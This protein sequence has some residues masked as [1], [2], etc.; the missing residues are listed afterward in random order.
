MDQNVKK[1]IPR[2]SSRYKKID[3]NSPSIMQS[4][5]SMSVLEQSRQIEDKSLDFGGPNSLSNQPDVTLTGQ[6]A[7]L[8]LT[9]KNVFSKKSF[10]LIDGK[11][12]LQVSSAE[13]FVSKLGLNDPKIKIKVVSVFGN[14]GDGKSY[15]LNYTFFNKSEVFRTSASQSSC[16]L[17]AWAAYDPTLKVIC[18][19]TEGLLGS[20]QNENQRT[21]L[22]LKILAVSDI[23]IYRTRSER[24]HRDLFT[25]LG[26]ASRA[27]THHFQNALQNV[28]L[29]GPLSALGPA[30][31][32]FH[33]TRH[34][35]PLQPTLTESPEDVLRNR[36]AEMKLEME[37]FSSLRYIGVQTSLETNFSELQ[38]AVK[39]ELEN[40]TVR[41][42]RQPAVVYQTLKVLNDKFC[43][44]LENVSPSLYFDQ[45]FTCP[46]SCLS[47]GRRCESSMGHLKDNL[48]H[49]CSS[50]CKYQHQYENCVY[51]CKKCYANGIEHVVRPKLIPSA[52]SPW[53]GLAKYVWSGY[54]IE[55][56]NCGEIYTSRQYWYGNKT[57]EES[58]TVRTE[59]THVWPGTLPLDAA[60]N[61]AQRVVD[62]VT[63]LS[64]AVASV[65]SQPTKILTSYVADQI[66]PKYWRP[67][68]EIKHCHGC[69]KWFPPTATKHHCR[70]CGEGFC[71]DC[72]SHAM[73]VPKYGWNTPVRVCNNCYNRNSNNHTASSI[74]TDET[75][76]RVR[77]YGEVVVNTLSTVA[78]VLEYP[79]DFI[80]DS[81]RPSYWVPD[82][83][84]THCHIC[85][86]PFSLALLLHHC[87]DCGQGVCAPCSSNRKPV[88]KR[89]W[90]KP[91]RVCDQCF[92]AD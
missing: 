62:G 31:I 39:N 26:S 47:C 53:Y 85:K 78:T 75:D 2:T 52:V 33:E 57:P 67:N 40:T 11:E 1:Q 63:Y 88:P 8:N 86:A 66:A 15:T 14:T 89:N 34:T 70:N 30:V 80:K 16:T 25:F 37:A 9:N 10:L 77:K 18:L 13:E 64:E 22:L 17:G 32:I 49:S 82:Y 48:P 55:C 38:Q 7:S 29:G 20:T 46:D 68:N 56:P 12:Q 45:Y 83:E 71:G 60:Q 50:I 35:R 73:P 28:G 76:V 5:D 59:I 6:F 91:V 4:L 54:T 42:P 92:I 87:R 90:E 3:A 79:K 51:I 84:I 44:E 43:G 61:T 24:L 23:V 58:V 72:S 41:S 69:K 21:R 19:D 81:A 36:F 74:A 27:F 65:C